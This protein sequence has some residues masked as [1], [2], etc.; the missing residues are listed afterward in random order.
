MRNWEASVCV[1]MSVCVYVFWVYVCVIVSICIYVCMLVCICLLSVYMYCIMC[2]TCFHKCAEVCKPLVLLL[3]SHPPCFLRQGLSLSPLPS[4]RITNVRGDPAVYVCVCAGLT[5][6]LPRL[7]RQC[8]THED[9][10]HLPSTENCFLKLTL[11][12]SSQWSILKWRLELGFAFIFY[13][14]DLTH[15]GR[16]WGIPQGRV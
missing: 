16:E 5:L 9:H 2:C 8:L 14:S 11:R 10:S 1:N 13:I 6:R 15:L 7:K 3:R 12:L 4:T